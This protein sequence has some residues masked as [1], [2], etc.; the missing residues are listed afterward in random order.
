MGERH[1]LRGSERSFRGE[2]ATV[3][4][5]LGDFRRSPKKRTCARQSRLGRLYRFWNIIEYW[6]PYRDLIGGSW[7]D[8]LIAFIPRIALANDSDAYK[9]QMLALIARVHDTHANLWSSLAVRPTDRRVPDS[10][11]VA[12]H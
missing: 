12:V 7:D 10:G 4:E 9:E 6:F 8:E 3:E 5:S 2:G 1:S 11:D